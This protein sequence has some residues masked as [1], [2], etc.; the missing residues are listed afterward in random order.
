MGFFN[1]Q[2]ILRPIL[3]KRNKETTREVGLKGNKNVDNTFHK[4]LDALQTYSLV[5]MMAVS[6]L[7]K[8]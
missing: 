5:L 4:Y 6:D 2:G 3:A 1:L 8:F 7:N